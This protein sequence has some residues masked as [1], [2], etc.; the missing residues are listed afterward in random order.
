VRACSLGVQVHDLSSAD[1]LVR[2]DRC[3]SAGSARVGVMQSISLSARHGENW[4][5]AENYGRVLYC[6]A[7]L[8]SG[9]YRIKSRLSFA[10][11]SGLSAGDTVGVHVRQSEVSF[12]KN[13]ATI[14]GGLA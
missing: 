14:P 4:Y 13:G 1:F 10:V 5:T 12:S 8:F 7:G 2:L 9:N 11:N 3:N 6:G